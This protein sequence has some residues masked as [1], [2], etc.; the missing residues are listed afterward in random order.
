MVNPKRRGN[1]RISKR[2]ILLEHEHEQLH[3]PYLFQSGAGIWYMTYREGGHMVKG[4]DRVHCVK[5][6]DEGETW[7]PWPGLEPE[8]LLRQFFRK[9]LQDGSL[10]SY[11]F[12]L[13][14]VVEEEKEAQAKA[15]ILRSFD[16]G[17]TWE[18]HLAPITGLPFKP[19]HLPF[20]PQGNGY[21]GLWGPAVEFPDGRLLWGLWAI[22]VPSEE[23]RRERY[24]CLAVESR[25]QGE[26]F[27][28]LAPICD[29]P[30]I[31]SKGPYEINVARLNSGSLL[32]VMRTGLDEDSPMVLARSQDGGCS[33]SKPEQM[34]YPGASPQL[35]LLNNGALV[36]T[37]GTREHVWLTVSWDGEGV[38]W[39]DPIHVYDGY[40]SGYTNIQTLSDDSFFFVYSESSFGWRQQPGGARIVRIEA[41]AERL[42]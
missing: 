26:S 15:V 24:S 10:I 14:D 8:W 22:R 16:D 1:L 34:Q 5:S 13:E 9:R 39:E 31:G 18:R 35:L 41:K 7:L 40:T 17:E 33:W 28:F 32:A 30:W 27:S 2:Q 4:G 42:P 21:G 3:F 29:E 25:D 38:H 6:A 36:L 37:F 11:R 23:R 12:S 20:L 19:G